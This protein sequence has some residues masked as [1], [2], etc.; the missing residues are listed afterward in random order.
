MAPPP[1]LPDLPQCHGNQEWSNDILAA[2]EI[3]ASLYSHGI[4]FL[5]SEDPEPLQLHL[6]SE[7]IHDQAIPILKALDIEMQ[8]SPWVATAATFILEVGLDLERVA[9]ALDFM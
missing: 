8:H 9:R 3:L 4:R 5:R 6:H 7:H 1:H 2:Y